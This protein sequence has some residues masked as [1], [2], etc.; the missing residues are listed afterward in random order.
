MLRA[1]DRLPIPVGATGGAASEIWNR[2]NGDYG[3]IFGTMPRHHFETLNDPKADPDQ[4]VGAAAGILA[5]SK[6]HGP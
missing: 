1:L 3:R 5:W 4:L 2:V 6:K